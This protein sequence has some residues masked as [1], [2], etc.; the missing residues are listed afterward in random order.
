MYAWGQDQEV[1]ILTPGSHLQP[2]LTCQ[3]ITPVFVSMQCEEQSL[4]S[5]EVVSGKTSGLD[6]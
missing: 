2:L 5:A 3:V 4:E 6:L 1:G